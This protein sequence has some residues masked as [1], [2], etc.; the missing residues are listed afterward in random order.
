MS[1]KDQG[2]EFELTVFQIPAKGREVL[3]FNQGLPG[4]RDNFCRGS[5]FVT[6]FVAHPDS[7]GGEAKK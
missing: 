3:E 1:C 2:T 7:F 6:F 5:F 4:K